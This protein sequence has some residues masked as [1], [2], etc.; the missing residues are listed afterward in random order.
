MSSTAGGYLLAASV[1]AKAGSGKA[2][3]RGEAVATIV[4]AS[5][6]VVQVCRFSLKRTS[7]KLPFPIPACP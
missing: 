3:L 5:L 1:K 4:G 7:T 6:H 2:S